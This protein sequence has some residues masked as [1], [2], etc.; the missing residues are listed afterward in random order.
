MF[1]KMFIGIFLGVVL[2]VSSL[3][4]NNVVVTNFKTLSN[5]KQ[6]IAEDKIDRKLFFTY[7]MTVPAT[8]IEAN[9]LN[10]VKNKL[11]RIFCSNPAL[12]QYVVD[13]HYEAIITYIY[14]N[15]VVVN[16]V[17]NSCE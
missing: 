12:R 17:I 11:K 7:N 4:A 6:A 9:V 5:G 15:D 14:T 8:N 3:F 10:E 16:I 13:K 1:R 2:S